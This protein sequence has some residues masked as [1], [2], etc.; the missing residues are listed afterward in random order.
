ME[1]VLKLIWFLLPAGAANMAPVFAEKLFPN[2]STPIDGG[3]LFRGQPLFGGHKTL[4][5]LLAGI[6]VSVFVFIFQRQ[7]YIH[8]PFVREISFFDYERYSWLPG[9]LFGVGALGGDLA[10]SFFKRRLGKNSGVSWFPFDQIDWMIGTLAAT[11]FLFSLDLRSAIAL[12][13]LSL[14][15]S[16]FVKW[17]GFLIKINES[18]I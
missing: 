18:P 17:I 2:W 14:A 12:V 16:L 4:R 11:A 15:L 5:G 13:V 6:V 8:V 7:A 1:L 10:K 9:V 3:M